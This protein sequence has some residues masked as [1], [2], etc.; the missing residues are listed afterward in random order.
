MSQKL[1]SILLILIL[2]SC[3]KDLPKLEGMDLDKWKNDKNACLGDRKEMEAAL[4]TEKTKL[5]GL[6]EM[7]I[8]K[9]LGKPDGNELSE[10]NQK[11]YMY[12]INA[13]PACSL[14]DSSARKLILRFNAMGYAQLTSIE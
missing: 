10:R 1:Y 7:D 9:L 5:K 11:F 12:Y 2:F 13:S 14:A 8:I 6:S 3:G 4:Q